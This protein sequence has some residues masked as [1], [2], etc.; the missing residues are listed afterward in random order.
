MHPAFAGAV[1]ATLNAVASAT[2][3]EHN[4]AKLI[5]R[6]NGFHMSTPVGR[7]PTLAIPWLFF[8][9]LLSKRSSVSLIFTFFVLLFG[10]QA[11]LPVSNAIALEKPKVF[12][13]Y[14]DKDPAQPPSI[15]VSILETLGAQLA[16]QAPKTV[17]KLPADWSIPKDWKKLGEKYTHFIVG[18]ADAAIDLQ[19][20]YKRPSWIV[21]KIAKDKEGKPH[22]I[23]Y[24]LL[25][26]PIWTSKDDADVYKYV[27]SDQQ[28][29]VVNGSVDCMIPL[30]A[31]I[32]AN[33]IGDQMHFLFPELRER[34][35]FLLR[36]LQAAAPD[37][38]LALNITQRLWDGLSGFVEPSTNSWNDI[39]TLK[40]A[41]G[42]LTSNNAKQP[43]FEI[44]GHFN[45]RTKKDLNLNIV[46][47]VWDRRDA[48]RYKWALGDD[49]TSEEA[50]KWREQLEL[51]R[52][53]NVKC[54]LDLADPLDWDDMV[55]HLT[56][57]L[58]S[59]ILSIASAEP[60]PWSC[61]P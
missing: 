43:E 14:I 61:D 60:T 35:V 50:H 24:G 27:C 44:R 12:I 22:L 41:C 39:E 59:V 19:N 21:G 18:E 47:R 28:T 32:A 20:R 16:G 17:E 45:N 57:H 13:G 1:N 15:I 42:N 51:W 3:R 29:P 34:Y 23:Y 56:P 38:E 7:A 52:L 53:K 5:R 33:F 31:P 9:S 26:L 36:C 25:F 40:R 54:T 48:E 4:S 8:N 30:L 2:K 46:N 37:S 55:Q 6:K 58:G 10:I 49:A 11:F